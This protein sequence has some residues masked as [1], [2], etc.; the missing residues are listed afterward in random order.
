MGVKAKIVT[1]LALSASAVIFFKKI[2]DKFKGF[3][4]FNIKLLNNLNPIFDKFGGKDIYDS[5]LD[6]QY[7]IS[8]DKVFINYKK[9][10]VSNIIN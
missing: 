2:S 8:V 9:G 6:K 5:I 10:A 4:F 7:D 1:F 3:N